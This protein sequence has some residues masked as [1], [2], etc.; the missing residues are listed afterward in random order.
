MIDI[1]E[2]NN[3][4]MCSSECYQ[5]HA[6]LFLAVNGSIDAIKHL[7]YGHPEAIGCHWFR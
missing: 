4:I 7:V 2:V 1:R 6:P 3:S 5:M